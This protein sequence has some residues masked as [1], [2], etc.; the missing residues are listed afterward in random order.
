MFETEVNNDT[1]NCLKNLDL[2][3][4]NMNCYADENMVVEK[5]LRM[6]HYQGDQ[7]KYVMS[8]CRR[9]EI[10]RRIWKYQS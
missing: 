10:L 3:E 2:M 7:M 4:K 5:D 6:E 8:Q 9:K 1:P